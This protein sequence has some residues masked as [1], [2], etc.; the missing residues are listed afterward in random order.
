MKKILDSIL[1]F[2]HLVKKN[3]F[4]VEEA[5]DINFDANSKSQDTRSIIALAA[6]EEFAMRSVDGA[7][8]RQIAKK[9]NVNHAA[10]SYYFGGK[11][12][13]YLEIIRT[14]TRHFS[15]LFA[16]V[17]AECGAF[18]ASE[19]K[20]RARAVELVKKFLT[21]SHQFYLSDITA[22]IDMIL[23]REENFPSEAFDI[24]FEEGI[25]F[26]LQTLKNLVAFLLPGASE[27]EVSTAA[28]ALIGMNNSV[29][30][31]KTAFLKLNSKHRLT[32]KDIEIFTRI[33]E[34][35]VDKLFAKQI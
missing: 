17:Y 35:A 33:I 30:S 29:S 28:I 10:I 13:M 25:R 21:T 27:S 23:K 34:R 18:L 5:N 6:I 12:E 24:V 14:M 2:N 15:K 3:R 16:P 4:K 20:S 31:C 22:K 8:T 1:K 19:K 11:W 26:H 7:R 9:A 32:P